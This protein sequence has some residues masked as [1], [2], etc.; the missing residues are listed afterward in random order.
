MKL[1][2]C[3]LATAFLTIVE[4]AFLH[5]IARAQQKASIVTRPIENSELNAELANPRTLKHASPLQQTYKYVM[6]ILATNNACSSFFGGPHAA[7][8]VL[9]RL[10]AQLQNHLLQNS[11]IGI[12]MLGP[13]TYYAPA[14]GH[15]EYRLFAQATV[16]IAGPFCKAKVFAAEPYVPR[17]GSFRPNTREARVLILLHELAH[18][19]RARTGSWL[20]PDDGNMPALSARNTALIETQCRQQ[21]LSIG[22]KDNEIVWH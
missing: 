9:S 18:L 1:Q 20:I 19:V 11:R 6:S 15:L 10:V 5:S 7:D 2:K 3:L 8:E 17:I 16:N 13:F 21:I 12:E 14:D 4:V 22:E